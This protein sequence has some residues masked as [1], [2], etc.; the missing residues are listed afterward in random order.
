MRRPLSD[1]YAGVIVSQVFQGFGFGFG[2]RS[3]SSNESIGAI[4]VCKMGELEMGRDSP[5]P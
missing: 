4:P 5:G 2:H 3:V 1:I